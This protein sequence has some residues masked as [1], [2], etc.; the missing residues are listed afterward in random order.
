MLAAEYG[1]K[2]KTIS[3]GDTPTEESTIALLNEIYNKSEKS[4]I[5]ETCGK[6]NKSILACFYLAF[7]TLDSVDNIMSRIW[8]E[9][10]KDFYEVIWGDKTKIK[11][12]M[13]KLS[14]LGERYNHDIK[15]LSLGKFFS[16]SPDTKKTVIQKTREIIEK[17]KNLES[18]KDIVYSGRY[19]LK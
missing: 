19:Y 15:Q 11:N 2:Y 6:N 12:L 8:A 18:L 5:N 3:L 1:I 17:F 14:I 9:R 10:E 4:F 16:V 13:I 7:N